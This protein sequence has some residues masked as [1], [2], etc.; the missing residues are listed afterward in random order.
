MAV[1]MTTV[2]KLAVLERPK[3]AQIMKWGLRL[4]DSKPDSV[5]YQYSCIST[6]VARNPPPLPDKPDT[7]S[8]PTLKS[9]QRNA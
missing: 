8:Q 2:A 5:E 4:M 9:A 6:N 1:K 7:C 3:L